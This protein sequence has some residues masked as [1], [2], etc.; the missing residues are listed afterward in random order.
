MLK[1]FKE[2]T[3]KPVSWVRGGIYV[4][5]LLLVYDSS[6]RWLVFE[7]WSR[8]DYSYGYI[9]PVVVIYLIWENRLRLASILPLPTWKAFG[10]VCV[11][12]A[13]FWLGELAGEQYTLYISLWLVF[14]GIIWLHNGWD[15]L[16]VILFPLIFMLAM[17][18]LPYFLTNRITFQLRLIS[19][20]LGVWMLHLYGMSAYREGNVIDLGFTQLQ[21]VDACSGLRY[22]MPLMVLSLLLAYWFRAHWWKRVVL[23]LS[24]IPLAIVVNSFRIA[25][26][27]VL[28]SF[29]GA[30]VAEG[31][32]H[33]FSGWL[34]FMFAIPLLLAEMWILRLLPPRKQTEGAKGAIFAKTMSEGDKE[35]KNG[36]S[37]I[38]KS[39]KGDFRVLLQPMFLATVIILILT[40]SLSRGVDFRQKVPISKPFSQFP[41]RVGAWHG[42]R[43]EMEQEFLDV[44]KFSDYIMADYTD[45]SGKSVNFY[46]AYYQ[47]QRKGESIH[48]P[49]TCLPGSGWDFNEAGNVIIPAGGG[50]SPMKV[51]RA[52]IIKDSSRELV[53]YWFPQRGRILTN[54]YQLKI[55]TFWDA[56]TKRRTDGALVRII[57]PVSEKEKLVDAEARLQ[58]FVQE[59]VPVLDEYIPK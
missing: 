23:F 43:G 53:Y 4:V 16:K 57:T 3:I 50:R 44:L 49:E 59:I 27:G 13:L 48:S 14:V 36:R 40:F 21:V 38:E 45:R 33:A 37:H 22:V 55:Y 31:F 26:T 58:G 6:L 41:M 39:R 46:V 8:E 18:P 52:F 20:K 34:I 5:S 19:S 2:I 35:D 10:L 56:L 1:F 24:S 47:D 12:I 28:Y 7:D 54:L 11:G 15:R 51:N 25:A 29:F 42:A 9:I 17:F 32:F 30:Q